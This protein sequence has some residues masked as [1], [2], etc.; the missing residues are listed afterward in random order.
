MPMA[1]DEKTA[2]RI[3]KVFSGRADV[4]EKKMMG[5]L[6]FLVTGGKCCSVSGK[7]GLWSES[8]LKRR[9][10]SFANRTYVPWRWERAP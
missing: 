8:T 5:G 9:P 2:E 3:R 6:C 4:V 1:Y 10:Q 7:G